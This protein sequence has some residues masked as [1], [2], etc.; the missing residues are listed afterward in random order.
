MRFAV[1]S[2]QAY[3]E[4][5]F[6]AYRDMVAQDPAFILH[7]GD[8]VTDGKRYEQWGTEFFSPLANVIDEV[9]ILPAIGNHEED[10]A[11]DRGVLLVDERSF[12]VEF[13]ERRPVEIRGGVV[14]DVC[15]GPL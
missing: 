14:R 6:S 7:L 1:A 4:G 8:L 2:C 15:F 12:G 10:G 5:Y 3:D 13:H 9:P 11:V